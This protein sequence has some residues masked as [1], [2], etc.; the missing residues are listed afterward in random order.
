MK[1]LL[2][3]CALWTLHLSAVAAT[4]P[5]ID[6]LHD[7]SR[8]V[9]LSAA[10]EFNST[11]HPDVARSIDELF[12]AALAEKDANLKFLLLQGAYVQ[13]FLL[14]K[15]GDGRADAARKVFVRLFATREA[16][17][18]HLLNA[19][20]TDMVETVLCLCLLVDPQLPGLVDGTLA[21]LKHK[22][23]RIRGLA[24][25][26]LSLGKPD[27]TIGDTAR[28]MAANDASPEVRKSAMMMLV[29]HGDFSDATKNVIRQN[30]RS[31]DIYSQEASLRALAAIGPKAE[32]DFLDDILALVTTPPAPW[33]PG[34]QSSQHWNAFMAAAS[35]AKMKQAHVVN[36]FVGMLGN[37]RRAELAIEA[38]SRMGPVAIEALPALEKTAA[39]DG[40]TPAIRARVSQALARIRASTPP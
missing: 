18:I 10:R 38:L 22:S 13:G 33:G 7:A 17:I 20:E 29:K 25:E 2:I 31:S 37:D 24:L 21:L 11:A 30:L 16:E 3:L 26:V 39:I 35:L 6:K 27:P 12:R 40:I 14:G 1:H 9:R 32:S 23:P 8:T 28:I 19:T 36:V 5:S 15:H 4:V 34:Y